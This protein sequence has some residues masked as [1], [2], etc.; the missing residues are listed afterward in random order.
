MIGI[1]KITNPSGRIYIGQSI[2]IDCRFK[3]Y[4]FLSKSKTQ[5]KLNRSFKKYGI[6]NHIF[7]IIE[8]C[9]LNQL[10]NRERHYQDLYNV[11]KKGLNCRLTKSDDKSGFLSQET[12]DKVS[13]SKKGKKKSAEAI[14]KSAKFFRGRKLTPEHIEKIRLSN[15]GKKRSEETKERCRLSKLGNTYNSK[16]VINTETGERY[17]SVKDM[18]QLTNYS[19][20]GFIKCLNGTRNNNTNFKYLKDV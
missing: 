10:N 4:T 17:D 13:K 7:E 9:E 14:E 1:Y 15:L 20:S 19:Y 16:K 18:W 12:K 2:N 6:E 5:V 3:E 11:V 8:E